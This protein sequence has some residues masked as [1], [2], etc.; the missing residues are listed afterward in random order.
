M[1]RGCRLRD[2]KRLVVPAPWDEERHQRHREQWKHGRCHLRFPEAVKAGRFRVLP[3]RLHLNDVEREASE[4]DADHPA[5]VCDARVQRKRGRLQ[6]PGRGLQQYE[7]EGH[8]A[9]A[10]DD[11]ADECPAKH[12]KQVGDSPR[13][14]PSKDHWHEE[15][16]H[17]GRQ[18]NRQAQSL[19]IPPLAEQVPGAD[20]TDHAASNCK[21]AYAPGVYQRRKVRPLGELRGRVSE[22]VEKR[23]IDLQTQALADE[24][25]NHG[26]GYLGPDK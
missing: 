16:L 8:L 12:R 15:K 9:P 5:Q 13:N 20:D 19:V 23:P 3:P 1:S 18:R 26:A 4:E 22:E 7:R 24:V 10:A 6:A 21:G 14:V 17:A 11:L 25:E 2:D